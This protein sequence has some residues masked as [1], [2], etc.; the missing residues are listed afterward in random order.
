MSFKIFGNLWKTDENVGGA[1]TISASDYIVVLDDHKGSDERD[2]SS[3]LAFFARDFGFPH[4][5]NTRELLNLLKICK[6]EKWHG[7]NFAMTEQ[8]EEI[9]AKIAECSS[10]LYVSNL[11][12]EQTE[13]QGFQNWARNTM[14]A[15][16]DKPW[17]SFW[18]VDNSYQA[19]ALLYSIKDCMEFAMM[20]LPSACERVVFV[21][22]RMSFFQKEMNKKKFK[23][24]YPT[25]MF[26]VLKG[27]WNPR[28]IQ[29]EIWS[30]RHDEVDDIPED[31][32]LMLSLV[33]GESWL[34]HR[35][36]NEKNS[37]GDSMRGL[38]FRSINTLSP[39]EK[40]TISTKTDRIFEYFNTPG[41]KDELTQTI[42]KRLL[43][44]REAFQLWRKDGK[45]VING[46]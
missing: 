29:M 28:K 3:P 24:Q 26:P 18:P 16:N 37:D 46:K 14:R 10:T 4:G 35:L 22:D 33:D 6:A 39:R 38:A 11:F 20:N 12:R 2:K 40:E 7:R 17:S 43:R 27:I 42:H 45:V 34:Y 15:I 5:L 31:L 25:A 9:V 36:F 41:T 8:F 13:F 19:R 23:D 44:Y 32:L 21:V 1:F 30:F